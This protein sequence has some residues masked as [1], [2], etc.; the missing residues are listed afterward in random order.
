MLYKSMMSRL[1]A[2]ISFLVCLG[3]SLVMAAGFLSVYEDLP[4][5]ASL[6]EVPGSA[7]AF[8]SQ[9]GRIVEVEAKGVTDKQTVTAFYA[10]ALPQLGWVQDGPGQYHRE[11]EVL[12]IDIVENGKGVISARFKVSPK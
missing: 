11:Q 3:P 7:L 1:I 9:E 8:D 5:P 2:V 4:L 12:R 6:A 10:S